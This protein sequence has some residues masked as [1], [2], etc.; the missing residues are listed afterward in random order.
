MNNREQALSRQKLYESLPN[1]PLAVVA[2]LDDLGLLRIA[3]L[4]SAAM[5]LWGFAA[6]VEPLEDILLSRLLTLGAVIE[7]TTTQ[8]TLN[9]R[10]GAKTVRVKV[11]LESWGA[12][13]CI[14]RR[15]LSRAITAAPN[16][17]SGLDQGLKS[18]S[19]SA[20]SIAASISTLAVLGGSVLVFAKGFIPQPE[21][22][23]ATPDKLSQLLESEL[24]QYPAPKPNAI[25]YWEYS[26]NCSV[27]RYIT[28]YSPYLSGQAFT[29]IKERL[30]SE[31][32]WAA[33]QRAHSAGK[34]HVV[35]REELPEDN[36]LRQVMRTLGT[37]VVITYP[38]PGSKGCPKG[39]LST[40]Y[41][42]SLS[43]LQQAKAVYRLGISARLIADIEQQ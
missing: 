10:T 30:T 15:S 11:T 31:Q 13:I 28:S 17:I 29:G 1:P 35:K 34:P 37:S 38:L 24:G 12:I 4:T 3:P 5:S 43:D 27:R 22:V 20:K 2:Y 16:W 18:L 40:G 21:P 19:A 33:I 26:N 14:E 36:A 39:Y 23:T 9:T 32:G 42:S 8:L 7:P 6:E 25:A 41:T